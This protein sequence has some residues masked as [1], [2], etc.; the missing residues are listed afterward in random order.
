MPRPGPT[1]PD[2]NT[3]KIVGQALLALGWLF[4]DLF[5]QVLQVH[6][7]DSKGN[8]SRFTGPEWAGLAWK[9]DYLVQYLVVC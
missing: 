6:C 2:I 8:S 7:S 4:K 3:P 9:L 1:G 5:V